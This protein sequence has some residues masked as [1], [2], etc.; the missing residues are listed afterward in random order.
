VQAPSAYDPYLHPALARQR[1]LEVIG[2]L[3]A[4]GVLSPTAARAVELEP[5]DLVG[6]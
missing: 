5:L 2:E 6:T 1:Q 3:Q 4:T